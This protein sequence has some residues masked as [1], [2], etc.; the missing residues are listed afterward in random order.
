MHLKDK[1][2]VVT[3]IDNDIGKNAALDLAKAGANVALI[4]FDAK[5]TAEIAEN[6]KALGQRALPI[7]ADILEWESVKDA[8][9][10]ILSEFPRIDILFNNMGISG[11]LLS[12]HS[13]EPD[14]DWDLGWNW[15]IGARLKGAFFCCKAA[16]EPMKAQNYGRIVNVAP[17]QNN[18]KESILMPYSVSKAGVVSMTKNLANEVGAYNIRVNAIT[19]TVTETP[20]LRNEAQQPF[21][22]NLAVPEALTEKSEWIG[23]EETT[24]HQEE[25]RSVLPF[26]TS[27]EVT[28]I[29]GYCHDVSGN[30]FSPNPFGVRGVPTIDEDGAK[31]TIE[32]TPPAHVGSWRNVLHGGVISTLLDEAIILVGMASFRSAASTASLEIRFRNPAPTC[33]KLIISANRTKMSQ[34][35]VDVEANLALEDGTV[36]ATGTGKVMCAA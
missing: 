19:S 26:F 35:T 34:K 36:C 8:L 16:L 12:S 24:G 3:G 5:I 7:C 30:R 9:A 28:F 13:D 2:A 6:I 32:Y 18:E 31:I 23:Q 29:T 15:V 14:L 22:L 33:T 11:P 17:I 10:R 4:D 25:I 1:F 27:E 20:I 21:T